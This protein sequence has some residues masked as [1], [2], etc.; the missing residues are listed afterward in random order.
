MAKRATREKEVQKMSVETAVALHLQLIAPRP[1]AKQ[2][3][4]ELLVSVRELTENA[5][6][7]T[8]DLQTALRR[9]FEEGWASFSG[10][11]IQVMRA[12]R[13]K[14]QEIADKATAAPAPA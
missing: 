11:F 5:M 14:I 10:E 3:I 6:L 12:G 8:R 1:T 4:K 7:T 9:W 13:A 2:C